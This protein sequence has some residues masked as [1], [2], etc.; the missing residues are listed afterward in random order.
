[1]SH[2]DARV[3]RD[4]LMIIGF[5]IMLMGYMFG[6]VM[7]VIGAF[8]MLSCVVPDVLYNKCPH[9]QRRLGRNAGAFCQHCGGKLTD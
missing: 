2:K 7:T 8:V 1:M 6:V 9:C 5:V 3:L 4:A